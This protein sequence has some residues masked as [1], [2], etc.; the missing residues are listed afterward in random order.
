M[1]E[2]KGRVF[3]SYCPNSSMLGILLEMEVRKIKVEIPDI[4][5]LEL[6]KSALVNL[7]QKIGHEIKANDF[8]GLGAV[9]YLNNTEEGK[10]VM[11]KLRNYYENRYKEL[12]EVR[13]V[14]HMSTS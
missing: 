1:A 11:P 13:K 12:N 2:T 9:D 10:A 8:L 14:R 6:K 7:G 4:D 3:E 5:E